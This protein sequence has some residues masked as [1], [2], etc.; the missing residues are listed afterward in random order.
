MGKRTDITLVGHAK[1]DTTKMELNIR[2]DAHVDKQSTDCLIREVIIDACLARA[3][4][5]AFPKKC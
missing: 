3:T 5:M 2:A 1:A 4:K